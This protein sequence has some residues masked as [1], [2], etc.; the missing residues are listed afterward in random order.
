MAQNIGNLEVSKTFSN[1]LLSNISAPGG[2]DYVGM[3]DNLLTSENSEKARV[4]DG[5]GASS[6]LY[7]SKTDVGVT[8]LPQSYIS[9]S[10]IVE[11]LEAMTQAQNQALT[12]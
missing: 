7:L 10:R 5:T 2:G 3:P 6:P 9:I 4:Q 12:L 11:T 1:V 8:S